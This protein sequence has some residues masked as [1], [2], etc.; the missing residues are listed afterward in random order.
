MKV[1]CFVTG[2]KGLSFVKKSEESECCVAFYSYAP[3]RVQEALSPQNSS[4][5]TLKKEITGI[6]K[7]RGHSGELSRISGLSWSSHW[8]QIW[9]GRAPLNRQSFC[10]SI[11]RGSSSNFNNIIKSKDT[12]VQGCLS[13]RVYHQLFTL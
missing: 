4:N 11:V 5:R 8:S 2:R 6:P 1:I 3:L 9:Y 13:Q 12:R 10:I 7:K